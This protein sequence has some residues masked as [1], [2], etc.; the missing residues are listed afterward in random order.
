MINLLEIQNSEEYR[1]PTFIHYNSR[2]LTQC[3]ASHK[4]RTVYQ[5]SVSTQ[6][7][8]FKYIDVTD[9][10]VTPYVQRVAPSACQ[11][12]LRNIPI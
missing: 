7:C 8:P 10:A 9:A 1:V 11:K 4:L 12:T 3:S 5:I 6:F 2:I